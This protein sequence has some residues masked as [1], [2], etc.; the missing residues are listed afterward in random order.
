MELKD[1]SS[2]SYLT[3]QILICK[4]EEIPTRKNKTGVFDEQIF[5]KVWGSHSCFYE[6]VGNKYSQYDPKQPSFLP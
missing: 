2:E 1:R 3:S 5:V 6:S 4:L